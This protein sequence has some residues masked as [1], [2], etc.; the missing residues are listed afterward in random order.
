MGD[1]FHLKWSSFNHFGQRTSWKSSF[2]FTQTRVCARSNDLLN[3][4]GWKIFRTR[5]D[6]IAVF[7]I[8]LSSNFFS[9][10]KCAFLPLVGVLARCWNNSHH[11]F[12][13]FHTFLL[14]IMQ[15]RSLRIVA[16]NDSDGKIAFEAIIFFVCS[17]R[18]IT[19]KSVK[20]ICTIF[21]EFMTKPKCMNCIQC[22]CKWVD[23][24]MQRRCCAK[25]LNKR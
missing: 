4:L 21:L 7:G 8:F 5:S 24:K 18:W 3:F 15:K 20:P 22:Q 12:F 10:E 11:F 2:Y 6:F 23:D 1:T 25:A 17:L 14:V 19:G 9:F 16:R 13:A